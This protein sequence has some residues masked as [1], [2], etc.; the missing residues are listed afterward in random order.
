MVQSIVFKCSGYCYTCDQQVD[1]IAYND[2]FRDHFVCSNCGSIPRERALMQV[3]E[4]YFPNWRQAI[5]HESSP[6]GRGASSRL[7]KECSNYIPSH[8]FPEHISGTIVEGI[9]CENLE[10]LSFADESVDLHITQDVLEHLFYPS[11][12][13]SEINRT[14]KPGGMH[15]F[16]VPI[17]NKNNPSTLRACINNNGI[18]YIMPEV[19]HGNPVGDGRAL[20]T[21]DWGFDICWHIFNA[22]GLF[23]QIINI[24]DLSKGIR[25]EYIEVLVTFKPNKD[26]RK[27]IMP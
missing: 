8:F 26:E 2:W 9:R 19:Y 10:E 24:D 4:T 25:A 20:V 11:K 1:F 14:L 22:S 18:K 13:F 21:V 23:T 7:A 27:T 6:C 17:V 12:A 5:V 16:T 15:I 3:I